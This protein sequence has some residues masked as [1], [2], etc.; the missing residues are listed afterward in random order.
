MKLALRELRRQPG[1]FVTAT[2][3]LTL[4][5]SLLMLLGGLLDGLLTGATSAVLAQRGELIVYSDTAE[6]SF[7]RSR[8]ASDTDGQAGRW[9]G[10]PA[11]N[12]RLYAD[13]GRRNDD[14]IQQGIRTAGHH[15]Y[16]GKGAQSTVYAFE[17]ERRRGIDLEIT[18]GSGDAPLHVVIER[19]VDV[20]REQP[21]GIEP[22]IA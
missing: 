16:A 9:R 8:I 19:H 3:I 22:Q 20:E 1:R 17:G 12:A 2:V 15:L 4:I 11:E 7:P 14:A 10:R 13:G 6:D 21:L 5:A 18:V